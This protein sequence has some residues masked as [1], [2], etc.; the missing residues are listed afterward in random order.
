MVTAHEFLSPE[1]ICVIAC[2]QG[3]EKNGCW[4][5]PML[6]RVRY[7]STDETGFWYGFG[8]SWMA[9][10]KQGDHAYRILKRYPR[11]QAQPMIWRRFVM[12]F[13]P[14]KATLQANTPGWLAPD[15]TFYETG[16]MEHYTVAE[17][18]SIALGHDHAPDPD[19]FLCQRGWIKVYGIGM[20]ITMY[21]QKIT[22]EQRAAV[23]AAARVT[24]D[25]EWRSMVLSQ[26][27]S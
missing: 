9:C 8:S 21:R 22:S 27:D 20:L 17:R 3:N 18:L 13:P 4:S 7:D 12:D 19:D 6:V 10:T 24:L 11:R 14:R 2:W 25:D 23:E 5:D 16:L 15:G 1:T 26:L